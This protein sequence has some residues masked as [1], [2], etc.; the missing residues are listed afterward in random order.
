MSSVEQALAGS[1][2]ELT[3]E[4]DE[5]GLLKFIRPD[6]TSTSSSMNSVMMT[7]GTQVAST[8]GVIHLSDSELLRPKAVSHGLPMSRLGTSTRTTWRED[9]VA[10]YDVR[11]DSP[12]RTYRRTAGAVRQLCLTCRRRLDNG[13]R[14]MVESATLEMRNKSG[15]DATRH[16]PGR[17][18]S[19]ITNRTEK[20]L[21]GPKLSAGKSLV[22]RSCR[23]EDCR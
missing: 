15:I 11:L 6:F 13:D 21:I 5:Y 7:S 20:S 9:A 19:M 10:F 22:M 23:T 16:L 2:L 12:N 17:V 8:A 18:Y 1:E 3:V 14:W 4:A